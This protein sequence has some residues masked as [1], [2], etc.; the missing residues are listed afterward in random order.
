MHYNMH[1]PDE[2]QTPSEQQQAPQP[3]SQAQPFQPPEVPAPQPTPPAFPSQAAPMAPPPVKKSHKKLWIIL[4]ASLFVVLALIVMAVIMFMN[5][6]QKSN[7]DFTKG[8]SVDTLTAYTD[9]SSG[10][11]LKI[12]ADWDVKKTKPD[13]KTL[14]RLTITPPAG[15]LSNAFDQQQG[16][17]LV[18]QTTSKGMTEQSFANAVKTGVLP[19]EQAKGMTISNES[20]IKVGNMPTYRYDVSEQTDKSR[21]TYYH[22]YYMAGTDTVCDMYVVAI[23]SSASETLPVEA[24]ATEILESFRYSV[25]S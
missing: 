21:T 4:G 25:K 16:I 9:K 23:V 10:V 8:N 13:D 12:P 2:Q 14:V 24:H 7:N 20:E 5:A 11:S 1:M 22:A 6:V 18:C 19:D 15:S 3:Q 17:D